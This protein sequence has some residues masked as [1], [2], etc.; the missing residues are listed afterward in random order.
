MKMLIIVL[1]AGLGFYLAHQYAHGA[2]WW[3]P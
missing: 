3:T 2:K 1:L